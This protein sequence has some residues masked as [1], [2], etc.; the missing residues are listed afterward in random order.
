MHEYKNYCMHACLGL[1]NLLNFAE[2][3]FRWHQEVQKC[4]DQYQ[5]VPTDLGYDPHLVRTHSD[6]FHHFK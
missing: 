6:L 4:A 3:K 2:L 5:M 1:P